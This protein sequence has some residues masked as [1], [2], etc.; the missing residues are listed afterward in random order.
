MKVNFIKKKGNYLLVYIKRSCFRT[1]RQIQS[2]LKQFEDGH[3]S[4]Y[5]WKFDANCKYIIATFVL[6]NIEDIKPYLEKLE[7]KDD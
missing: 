2:E 3:I 7:S 1:A 5:D 6:R 4:Y